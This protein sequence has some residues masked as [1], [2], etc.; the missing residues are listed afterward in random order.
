MDAPNRESAVCNTSRRDHHVST[1]VLQATWEPAGAEEQQCH[2]SCYMGA[3]RGRGAAVPR[4][5]LHGNPPGPRSSSATL[6]ATWEPA[7]AE[8]Q[9]CHASCYMP[10]AAGRGK[11]PASLLAT[12]QAGAHACPCCMMAFEVRLVQWRTTPAPHNSRGTS[13]AQQQRHQRCTS[14]VRASAAHTSAQRGS[15]LQPQP[16]WGCGGGHW[17]AGM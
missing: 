8:E 14:A 3:R 4:F 1:S 17:D 9:Q 5:L 16:H 7:G 2:A 6:P 13:A 15:Q 12:A 11:R 10:H